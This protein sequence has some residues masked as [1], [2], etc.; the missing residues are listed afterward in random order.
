MQGKG[1]NCKQ[2]H[3]EFKPHRK[4]M[5]YCTKKC[6]WQVKNLRKV[7][8]YYLPVVK[9]IKPVSSL[10][11]ATFCQ[12]CNNAF[13]SRRKVKYCSNVCARKFHSSKPERKEYDRLRHYYLDGKG[14]TKECT[15]PTCNTVFTTNQKRK[16][17]TPKCRPHY[18]ELFTNKDNRV[19]ESCSNTYLPKY[20]AQRFCSLKCRKHGY[21]GYK[22]SERA[23]YNSKQWKL[24]RA[25]FIH[26]NTTINGIQL[27]N[28]YCIK[29]YI[30]QNR[31]NDMYAVD[32]IIPRKQSGSDEFDNLQSLCRHH[33]QSKSAVE[34]NSIKDR[35]K[36][37]RPKKETSQYGRV[38]QR[39]K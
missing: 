9:E 17:C 13:V 26:G 27:S 37:G 24:T 5:I 38:P 29:C 10:I 3:K 32:H 30:Q 8:P 39:F 2:C 22:N 31:L 1:S 36:G 4:G 18:K 11:Y 25:T 21:V 6:K 14:V 12:N 7:N 28:K 15:C 19:C 35:N 34:G 33:H 20:R 16:Y 23:Y